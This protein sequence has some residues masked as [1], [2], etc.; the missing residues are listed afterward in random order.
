MDAG[1]RKDI[2]SGFETFDRNLRSPPAN[3]MFPSHASPSGDPMMSLRDV[4][5]GVPV[6]GNAQP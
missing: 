4:E 1:L 6:M 5:E 3:A 2:E